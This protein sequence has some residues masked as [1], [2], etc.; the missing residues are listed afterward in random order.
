MQSKQISAAFDFSPK[1]RK[2]LQAVLAGVPR[3]NVYMAAWAISRACVKL[4]IADFPNPWPHGKGIEPPIERARWAAGF[5][6]K[7][8]PFPQIYADSNPLGVETVVPDF[9][10]RSYTKAMLAAWVH[11]HYNTVLDPA[12]MSK[13]D[14]ILAAE[15]LIAPQVAL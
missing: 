1:H 6:G 8:E 7:P 10:D 13:P 12:Q 2:E 11:K 3:S 9:D 5:S 14:M 15:R 4:R